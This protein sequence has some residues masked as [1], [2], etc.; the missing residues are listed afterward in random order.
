MDFFQH[1]PELVGVQTERDRQRFRAKLRRILL[2]AT[3]TVKATKRNPP[4]R[5]KKAKLM[6][7]PT[8]DRWCQE[9]QLQAR[10]KAQEHAP[11]RERAS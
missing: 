11:G 7:P 10:I 4:T 9:V 3:N 1:V 8:Q 5:A 2:D 6:K